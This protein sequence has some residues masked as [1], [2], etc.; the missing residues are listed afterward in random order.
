MGPNEKCRCIF[1]GQRFH[2]N[3]DSAVLIGCSTAAYCVRFASDLSAELLRKC[4]SPATTIDISSLLCCRYLAILPYVGLVVFC[5]AIIPLFLV[6]A[7]FRD[8][9][10]SR[11]KALKLQDSR[12]PTVNNIDCFHRHGFCSTSSH[13]QKNPP[14]GPC[15]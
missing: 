6:F 2:S 9:T 11:Q 5:C 10:T 3:S 14:A 15:L 8:A 13:L 7:C 1:T 12:K 4:V